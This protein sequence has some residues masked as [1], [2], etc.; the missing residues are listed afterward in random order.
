MKLFM[1]ENVFTRERRFQKPQE[2]E[3]G[4][5]EWEAGWGVCCGGRLLEVGHCTRV[6]VTQRGGM[7]PGPYEGWEL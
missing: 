5:E 1:V 6:G 4:G 2:K 7:V 3:L